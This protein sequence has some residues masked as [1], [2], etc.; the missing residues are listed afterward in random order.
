MSI[1]RLNRLTAELDRVEGLRGKL[2]EA[3]K[4]EQV[5]VQAET[6]RIRAETAAIRQVLALN[7]P[8]AE[9]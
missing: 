6:D 8:E 9:A 3:I 7:T 5:A 4:A 2:I 1:E